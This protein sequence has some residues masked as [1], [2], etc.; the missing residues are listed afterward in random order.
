MSK[1]Y[2]Y[3]RIYL[4]QCNKHGQLRYNGSLDVISCQEYGENFKY[5]RSGGDREKINNFQVLGGATPHPHCK[6]VSFKQFMIRDSYE[7]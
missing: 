5:A 6:T 7:Q 2:I 1:V 4:K 3:I